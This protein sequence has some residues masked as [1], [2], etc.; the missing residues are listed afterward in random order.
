MLNFEALKAKIANKTKEFDKRERPVVP[1]SG[2]TSIILLPGWKPE[3]REVFWH[4]FGGHYIRDNAGKVSA[5][6]PCDS[7]I[8]NKPC[9]ICE[10]LRKASAATTDQATL[11]QIKQMN[12]NTV[13]L[14]N[15]IVLGENNNEPVV[16]QLSKTAF[17]QLLQTISVWMQSVFDEKNPQVICIKRSGTGFDTKYFVSM[18]PEKFALKQDTYS[19]MHNLD[20]YVNQRT[21][22]LMQK[23]ANAI[24]ATLGVS[25]ALPA[26]TVAA[27]AI[28]AP[29]MAQPQPVAQP[30][31]QV[32]EPQIQHA[33]LPATGTP[34]AG[35]APWEAP[36]QPVAQ[37]QA[38]ATPAPA[39]APANQAQIDDPEL[40][41]M[42][43][44]L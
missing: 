38:Q 1:K 16:F 2:D 7:A 33:D 22:A 40:M 10:M 30:A 29:V 6:Y 35:A 21:D 14:V 36:A 23:T 19:K 15:A 39:A 28:A 25:M 31:P 9:P 12:S 43:E 4:E 27:P 20:D 42:L 13:Y 44:G 32:V 34:V 8:Y 3:S 17:E 37:H 26:P 24:S 18:A 11:D 41:Q 5:F